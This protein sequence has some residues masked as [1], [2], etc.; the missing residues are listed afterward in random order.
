[1]LANADLP[2]SHTSHLNATGSCLVTA[3]VYSG[4]MTPTLPFCDCVPSLATKKWIHAP[5]IFSIN[6][7]D[8][9]RNWLSTHYLFFTSSD[10]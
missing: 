6:E 10:P 7:F 5:S 2:N 8:F 3:T 4:V 9:L 1:M